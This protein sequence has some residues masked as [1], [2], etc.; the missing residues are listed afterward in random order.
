MLVGEQMFI[1]RA[2]LLPINMALYGIS[3]KSH[4]CGGCYAHVSPPA[5]QLGCL[6]EAFPPDEAGCCRYLIPCDSYSP[7]LPTIALIHA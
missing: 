1:F 6:C 4:L 5:L 2:S 7:L 3:W